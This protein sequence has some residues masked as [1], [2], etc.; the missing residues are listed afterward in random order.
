MIAENDTLQSCRRGFQLS[1][2]TSTCS[3]LSIFRKFM[4]NWKLTKKI[5]F[6]KF[7]FSRSTRRSLSISPLDE[8]F[9]L[10][11]QL[12]SLLSKMKTKETEFFPPSKSRSLLPSKSPVPSL[13]MV[14]VFRNV[15]L[16]IR[17]FWR[18]SHVMIA[19]NRS[20]LMISTLIRRSCSRTGLIP[21]QVP[22]VLRSEFGDMKIWNEQ[23]I[24]SDLTSILTRFWK[25]HFLGSHVGTLKIKFHGT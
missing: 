16:L 14:I 18:R 23:V 19:P 7:F 24:W 6:Y 8:L 20:L 17:K 25:Y 11:N 15:I 5:F 3:F 1:I 10:L 13:S 9:V 12:L 22:M 2:A 21:S 4:I